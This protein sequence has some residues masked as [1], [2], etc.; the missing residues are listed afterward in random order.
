MSL[1]NA[2]EDPLPGMCVLIAVIGFLAVTSY[3]LLWGL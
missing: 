1:H 2:P 3:V